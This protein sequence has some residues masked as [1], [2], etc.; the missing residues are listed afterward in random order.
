[1]NRIIIMN[2]IENDSKNKIKGKKLVTRLLLYSDRPENI[3]WIGTFQEKHNYNFA[4]YNY[5]YPENSIGSLL[6]KDDL[7]VLY[8]R[9][10]NIDFVKENDI[11]INI[12][13]IQKMKYDP[14]GLNDSF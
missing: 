11:K 2:E 9:N 4:K 12:Q 13:T 5:Y 3:I 1:M 6:K 10:I 14:R 8:R 7:L